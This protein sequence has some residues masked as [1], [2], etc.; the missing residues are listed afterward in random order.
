MVLNPALLEFSPDL[1]AEE[2]RHAMRDYW[3]EKNETTLLSLVQ[4]VVIQPISNFVFFCFSACPVPLASILL[5]YSHCNI[6]DL[7]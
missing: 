5:V 7:L 3:H 6:C 2:L 1:L 4:P